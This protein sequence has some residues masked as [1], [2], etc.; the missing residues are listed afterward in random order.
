MLHGVSSIVVDKMVDLSLTFKDKD[1]VPKD[2]VLEYASE[3][4]SLGLLYMHCIREGDGERVLLNWKYM[5]LLFKATNCRNYAIEAVHTLANVK[6]LPPRLAHQLVWSRFVNTHGKGI[7]GNN[8]PCGLHMEHL[9]RV[10]KDCVRHLGANKTEKVIVRYS[11]CI[12]PVAKIIANFD[13]QQKSG[14]S[15]GAHTPSSSKK[16][17]DLIIKELAKA[18]IFGSIL[19]R[20]Y[21][22]YPS[23]ECNPT[24]S[25]K[26]DNLCQ[27]LNELVQTSFPG[28]QLVVDN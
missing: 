3:V 20:M 22:S 26:Y 27:W 14:H 2:H 1:A 28:T 17:Q 21:P 9:N 16:D 24:R 12:G 18:N 23:F 11:Q 5:L 8:V 15:S 6:L 4:V 10:C 19:G 25:L 7:P 13:E